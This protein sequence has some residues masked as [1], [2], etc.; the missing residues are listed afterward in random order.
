[1]LAQLT[2][3][4]LRRASFKAL[5]CIAL[6]SSS[7][8]SF[9][10]APSNV[11][12]L[13]AEAEQD[14]A[15]V[16][17]TYNGVRQEALAYI[18]RLGDSLLID[19][20]TLRRLAIRY[21]SSIIAERDGRLMAPAAAIAGLVWSMDAKQQ[22][23]T[24]A[25]DPHAL[26]L[27]DI[28]YQFTKTPPPQLPNWGGYVNYGL[29]GSSA[30]SGS[31]TDSGFADTLGAGLT[32]SVFG[33]Y[34]VGTAG[35]L[36]NSRSA[37]QTPQSITVLDVN[38][39][40]DDIPRKTSLLVGDAISTPGWWGRAVRFGGV[41]Y[42][43]NYALQPGFVTYPLMAVSGLAS[44]PSTAD[45]LMNNVRVAEQAVPAGPF[46][47]SNLPTMTGAGE[48]NMV[49]RD[50]FGQERVI[51]QPFYIAQ[52]LLR[53][54]LTEFSVG[55]GSGR[56]NYGIENFDYGGNLA[57]GWL[58]HGLSENLTGELRGEAD[59]DGA[60][61]GGGA[62]LLVGDIGVL[63]LGGTASQ[64][65][66]GN[67]SRYLIGFDRQTPF[68][69]A[70]ARVT[71]ASENYREIGDAGPQV[72]QSST[73]F[74]RTSFGRSGSLAFG[75][76]GQK[77]FRAE[78]L[79]IYS[80]S[81]S[82]SVGAR[83]FVTLTGAR[84]VGAQSQTQ[85]M[86]LLT[87]PLDMLTSA[88]VSVQTTRR[89]GDTARVGEASVQRSLPV[90]EGYGY[91]LRASTERFA[92]GGI[93]YAGPFGRYTAEAA[94]DNGRAALRASVAGGVAW[95]GDTVLFAQPIEQS[96]AVVRVDGLDGVRI[97][98][99]NQEI[100]H[101]ENGE[102]VVAQIPALNAVTID[103]DPLTVPIDMTLDKLSQTVVTLP[104][105]GVLID[106]AARR[107]RNAIVRLELP[108]GRPVPIGAVV[109]I[110]GR[111]ERFAVGHDGEAYLTRLSDQQTLI[112]LF[113]G[114]RCRVALP[115]DPAGP[116]NADVGPLRC[117]YLANSR[118]QGEKQ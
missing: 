95:V 86:V 57:Y 93:Q 90:G 63:S 109:E 35:F 39:R 115:L 22:H 114:K 10:E 46:T 6:A 19:T 91:Y 13:T 110:E 3:S 104:R 38:W 26:A 18:A 113:E 75:Y 20:D 64:G 103:V 11:A 8:T 72:S 81:Y 48:L 62:D 112:V 79:S 24:L 106:F 76:T 98:Q 83:A 21:D 107:D 78:P 116:A 73:A 71:R 96:F 55:A 45:I 82:V 25:S 61:L 17:V 2:P 42:G 59:N 32:A 111:A 36:I 56:L 5:A 43:T 66:R 34:G 1:M 101:T 16:T 68:V 7:P 12:T 33:P 60:A 70:G 89:E 85:A 77:Y 37:T 74:V 118:L 54:G 28:S 51:S 92:A 29:F 52:Q 117:S 97:L 14:L 4:W 31:A 100:G 27:N 69:S 15:V 88:T 44:V 84:L 99:S 94:T 105:T 49:V 41:Q 65:P 53:P 87:V 40:W 9:A 58:R 50:P 30:L 108:S 102:L 47:I 67:G 80:G 23:L